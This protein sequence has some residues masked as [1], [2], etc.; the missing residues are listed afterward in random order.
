MPSG[1]T[2][3]GG[4]GFLVAVRS[5]EFP[6]L[7]LRLWGHQWHVACDSGCS[8][9]ALNRSDGGRE[10]F[11][12]DS[13]D[14]VFE[15][16]GPDLAFLPLSLPNDVF[17]IQALD[18]TSWSLSEKEVKDHDVN[19]GDDAFMIG[20]FVDYEGM[21]TAVPSIAFRDTLVFGER[22]FGNQPGYNGNSSSS[23]CIAAMGTRV[24]P[25]SCSGHR[26]HLCGGGWLDPERQRATRHRRDTY[27]SC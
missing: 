26:G 1:A 22:Q 24:A 4:T 23:I 8:C 12:F 20:R 19:V 7:V 9:I 16:G 10:I 13:S 27:S 18:L 15:P 25:F 2:N 14:W 21:E 3:Y 6:E 5:E 17:R 11:H